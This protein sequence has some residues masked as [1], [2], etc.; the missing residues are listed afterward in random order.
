MPGKPH[1]NVI[2]YIKKS[3]Y[4]KFIQQMNENNARSLKSQILSW[5]VKI[6]YPPFIV[7]NSKN[8]RIK[9]GNEFKSKFLR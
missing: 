4:F 7:L 8:T 6:L 1:F 3:E 5:V 2:K 9:Y